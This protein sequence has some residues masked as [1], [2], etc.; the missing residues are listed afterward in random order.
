VACA[1][2]QQC[3]L[4]NADAGCTGT[5]TGYSNA[6]CTGTVVTVAPN[7]GQ[8]QNPAGNFASVYYDAAVVPVANCGPPTGPSQGKVALDQ[9]STICCTQ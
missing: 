9:P 2:C 5:A 4:V 8:C 3:A 1:L 6:D 7:N